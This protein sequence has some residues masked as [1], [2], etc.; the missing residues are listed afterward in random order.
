M[1]AQGSITQK[2]Y[3]DKLEGFVGRRTQYVKQLG[4]QNALYASFQAVAENYKK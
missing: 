2:E 4:N 3:M 1:V